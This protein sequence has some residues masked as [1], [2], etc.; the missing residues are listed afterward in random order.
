MEAKIDAERDLKELTA[1]E[2][3][4]IRDQEKEDKKEKKE[5]RIKKKGGAGGEGVEPAASAPLPEPVLTERQREAAR[6]EEEKREKEKQRKEELRRAEFHDKE[7]ELQERLFQ[8]QNKVS[9]QV[10]FYLVIRPVMVLISVG[11]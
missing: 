6:L 8:S 7:N 2:N 3:K 9:N 11:I 5:D 4:R 1:Q 10:F